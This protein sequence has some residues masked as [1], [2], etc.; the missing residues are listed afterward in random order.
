[1]SEL[2]Q[3]SGHEPMAAYVVEAYDSLHGIRLHFV[4]YRRRHGD[5][6]NLSVKALLDGL[7]KRGVFADDSSKYIQEIT[8]KIVKIEP[9]EQE[10]T[11]VIIEYL[12]EQYGSQC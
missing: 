5:V 3:N 1:M 8:H 12:K 4:H 11:E 6:D 10:H 7:V 2:E 9:Q